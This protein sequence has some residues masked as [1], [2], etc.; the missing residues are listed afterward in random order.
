MNNTPENEK[1]EII[2][3][4]EVFSTV[5][6]D[7]S[8]HR[9]IKKDEKS[10]KPLIKI[11]ACFLSLAVLI[12]GTVAVIK[13]IPEREEEDDYVPIMDEIEVLNMESDNFDTVTVTN[14][15]GEFKF[16]SERTEIE[17]SEE[18]S[19]SESTESEETEIAVNWYLS[20]YD[21][22]LISS[23]SAAD[24]VDGLCYITAA[25]K[26]TEKT[27]AECGLDNPT[28]K[29]EIVMIDGSKITLSLGSASPD[30]TGYYFNYSDNEDIYLVSS[31]VK[32]NFEFELLDLANTDVMSGFPLTESM[33][34]YMDDNS[35]LSTFDSITLSGENLNE[36]V[37]ITPNP[38]D[39]I[40]LYKTTAPVERRAQNVEDIFS[41]FQN[42]LSVS[43]AY[44]LDASAK[45]LEEFGL[46]SPDFAMTMKIGSSSHTF[47]FKLQED[48]YYAAVCDGEKL[49]KKVEASSLSFINYSTTDFYSNWVCME[50]ITDL[51]GFTFKTSDKTYEFSLSSKENE[52][53][54]T[55]TT[56]TYNGN[57][58][59]TDSFKDFYEQC[60]SLTCTDFSI[61]SVSGTADYTIIFSLASGENKT[62]EFYK[63]GETRYQ[64]RENGVDLGKVNSS[65]INK[66]IKALE[67]LF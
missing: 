11:L 41:I 24:T 3:N 62:Y 21:K 47:K 60:L 22:E 30:Q 52:D 58:I 7:P 13:L 46:N 26:I 2:E 19:S 48:G 66:I 23:P 15:N 63:S 16:Y 67:K 55:V 8:E 20:D 35:D 53:G 38:E 1:N 32:S 65:A 37:V 31:S 36:T 4:D 64:Y 54:E 9:K 40:L 45:S 18:E 6:S 10:K 25:R 44:S 56:V 42:G 50:S 61:D 34:D 43:G 29:A 51:S 12:G 5:F 33:T 49:I 59:D 57:E 14:Q 28:L 39:A 27:S 17:S